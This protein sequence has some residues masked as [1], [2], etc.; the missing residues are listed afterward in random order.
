MRKIHHCRLCLYVT[1]KYQLRLYGSQS[2]III[3]QHLGNREI[4]SSKVLQVVG[5]GVVL[6]VGLP[7]IIIFKVLTSSEDNHKYK[8]AHRWFHFHFH[9]HEGCSQFQSFFCFQ[10]IICR[11]FQVHRLWICCSCSA[12]NLYV[13]E[14]LSSEV[15]FKNHINI[16]QGQFD[17]SNFPYYIK[18]LKA[19]LIGVSKLIFAQAIFEAGLKEE[20]LP[21][22]G[23]CSKE[24]QLG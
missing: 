23:S 4:P 7:Y 20:A 19:D 18:I 14:E 16:L 15:V 24:F 5:T 1:I 21:D 11:S 13:Y 12:K 22:V 9:F 3:H 8:Q 2:F 10:A 6:L 17:R